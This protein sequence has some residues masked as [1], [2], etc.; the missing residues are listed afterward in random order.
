MESKKPTKLSNPDTVE[1]ELRYID[2]DNGMKSAP[3]AYLFWSF[4]LMWVCGLH[5]FYLGKPLTGLLWLFTFGLFAV[6]QIVD[7]IRIR[8]MVATANGT[9]WPIVLEDE[10]QP[11]SQNI[12]EDATAPHLRASTEEQ[13][14]PKA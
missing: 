7:L 11:P 14:E 8:Q 2:I 6:G 12:A 4:G 9:E 13:P 10:E 3:V 5:R 1:R